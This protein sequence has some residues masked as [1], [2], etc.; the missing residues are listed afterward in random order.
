MSS[1]TFIAVAE[2]I[3]CTLS[4]KVGGAFARQNDDGTGE[5][6]YKDGGEAKCVPVPECFVKNTDWEN[7]KVKHIAAAMW[8]GFYG[9]GEAQQAGADYVQYW[10]R[11]QEAKGATY[12]E[13]N[14][15]EFPAEQDE[16]MKLMTWA[17]GVVQEATTLPLSIDSSNPDMLR[18]GLD[19]C[20][21]SRSK[22]MVN[23]VSLERLDAVELA[24]AAGA[25]VIAGATGR[26]EM[27]N[28]VEERMTNLDELTS[29]LK[30]KGFTDADIHYDPLVFPISVDGKNGTNVIETV[31]AI[32]ERFGADVHFAPGLSNV[33]FGMPKR[34][35]INTVFT[36]MCWQAGLDGAIVDPRHVSQES[37]QTMDT[38]TEAYKIAQ[39]LL[40]GEDDFGMN[41]ITAS[42]EGLI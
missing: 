19:A 8:Q 3:H 31:K 32:R 36:H 34:K 35:L 11:L 4:R 27:P 10:A 18:V 29:I 2:N 21:M 22:P 38:T 17:A 39:A 15:D 12:Q 40:L 26:D 7:G 23:S 37:L 33:S 14:V 24:A 16:R 41:Y 20:D 42:R 6:L 5:I 1:D 30:G 25:V 28:T 9:N 13:I